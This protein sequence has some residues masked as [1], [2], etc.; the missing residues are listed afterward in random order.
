MCKRVKC[1][2][3]RKYA[4]KE[5][6]LLRFVRWKGAHLWFDTFNIFL[7]SNDDVDD[8]AQANIYH[9]PTN[10][11]YFCR[12]CFMRIPLNDAGNNISRF[13]HA[14]RSVF[15]LN[16][17][18]LVYRIE[19]LFQQWDKTNYMIQRLWAH[20]VL[21]SCNGHTTTAFLFYVMCKN[22]K[23]SKVVI[24]IVER[25]SNRTV[26]HTN[27]PHCEFTCVTVHEC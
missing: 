10:K 24:I 17:T 13:P 3:R 25:L 4:R 9:Q 1:F 16:W 15:H 19:I 2:N 5:I 26:E 20:S 21:L 12:T 8:D 11:S 14:E 18:H 27:W 22:F 7:N 6:Y 23:F